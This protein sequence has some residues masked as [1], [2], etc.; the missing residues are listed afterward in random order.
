MNESYCRLRAR[1][2]LA[3]RDLKVLKEHKR[4]RW[5]VAYAA[6]LDHRQKD[7]DSPD[8]QLPEADAGILGNDN[9]ARVMP[10]IML[11]LLPLR[12]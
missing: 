10:I 9:F 3:K 1:L 5:R 4:S 6:L 11:M 8:T 7:T 12:C 2:L